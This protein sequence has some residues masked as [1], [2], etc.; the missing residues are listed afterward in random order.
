MSI[1]RGEVASLTETSEGEELWED[2]GEWAARVIT[3]TLH[4]QQRLLSF[5]GAWREL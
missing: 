3:V 1:E 5:D 4:G 2:E